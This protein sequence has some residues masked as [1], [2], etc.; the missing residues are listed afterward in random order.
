MKILKNISRQVLLSKGH[1]ATATLCIALGVATSMIVI[2]SIGEYL[3]PVSPESR[4]D[5]ILCMNRMKSEEL[6]TQ[7]S[8]I[9]PLTL[10]FAQTYLSKTQTQELYSIYSKGTFPR[11]EG[12]ATKSLPLISCDGDYWKIFDFDFIKGRP[13]TAEEFRSKANVAVISKSLYDQLTDIERRTSKISYN[14]REFL[15]VGVVSD[16]N[17]YRLFTNARLWIPYSIF[18][19]VEGESGTIGAFE[20]VY[21]LKSPKDRA[22]MVKEVAAIVHRLNASTLN[23]ARVTVSLPRTKL[24]ALV[25]GYAVE[26]KEAIIEFCFRYGGLVLIIL[27]LPV[28][29]L[30]ILNY[31]HIKDRYAEM[32][33][34]RSFG[35]SKKD[36]VIYFMASNSLVVL[37]G[38]AVGYIFS[39]LFS[40]IHHVAVFDFER[41]TDTPFNGQSYPSLLSFAFVVGLILIVSFISGIF[42]AVKL[43]KMNISTALK[44]GE[45]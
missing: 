33:T 18:N 4:I 28:L 31:N 45:Q 22:K 37:I 25:V 21:L 27:L 3:R 42:P 44:G 36:V 38:G 2:N 12:I 9:G 29:N 39:F 15:I 5:R 10:Y 13:F 14:G 43:A 32:A 41:Y 35:A 11:L 23:E 19:E 1:L 34:M 20:L 26:E 8:N 7:S 24:K 17:S 16:A 30:T 6:K 40:R